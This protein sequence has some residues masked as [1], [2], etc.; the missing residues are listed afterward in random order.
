MPYR[1]FVDSRGDH[2]RVWDVKPSLIDRRHQVR[3]I[4]VLKILHPVRRARPTRRIDMSR[5]RLYF[6]PGETGWL[7]FESGGERL[8]LTPIPEDWAGMSVARLEAL[9]REAVSRRGAVS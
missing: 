8:R 9:R 7:C 4:R 5:S 6:P 3:R 1:Y 2:W